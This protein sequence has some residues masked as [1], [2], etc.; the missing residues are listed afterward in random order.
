MSRSEH[1]NRGAGDPQCWC[2]RSVEPEHEH[3]FEDQK[4]FLLALSNAA[5]MQAQLGEV[6]RTTP[7]DTSDVNQLRSHL[8]DAHYEEGWVNH[9]LH[10]ELLDYHN[11]EHARM[12]A[13]REDEREPYT[14]LGDSHFH[15][16]YED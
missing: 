6:A 3:T 4:R 11:E 13:G 2:G 14:T 9:A 1:F 8:A 15:H 12:D 5:D 7:V 16:P 10:D